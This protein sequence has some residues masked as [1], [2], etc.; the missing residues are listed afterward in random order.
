MP[1]AKDAS[2]RLTQ[3]LQTAVVSGGEALSALRRHFAGLEPRDSLNSLI[4]NA[5]DPELLEAVLGPEASGPWLRLLRAQYDRFR[6]SYPADWADV[7]AAWEQQRLIWR[8]PPSPRPVARDYPE[9]DPDRPPGAAVAAA[10][11]RSVAPRRRRAVQPAAVVPPEPEPV[12]VPPRPSP[13]VDE[14]SEPESAEPGGPSGPGRVGVPPSAGAPPA[15]PPAAP[16]PSNAAAAGA[17]S[18]L[19]VPDPASSEAVGFLVERLLAAILAGDRGAIDVLRRVWVDGTQSGVL[20]PVAACR[21]LPEV[22]ERL[23]ARSRG[24]HLAAVR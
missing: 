3:A 23:Q 17:A 11:P 19:D 6:R 5:V 22:S 13:D 1:A 8:P 14:G 4:Q 24:R 7:E 16:L 12:A 20:Y 9:Q 21:L 15:P 2:N 10:P 18:V